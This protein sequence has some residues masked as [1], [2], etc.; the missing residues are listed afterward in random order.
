MFTGIVSAIGRIVDVQALGADASFGN[1]L[2]VEAPGGWLANSA[3]GDSIA[4][5]GACMTIV[6]IDATHHRFQVEV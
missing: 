1:A 6:S 5:A 2:T 3:I 4:L